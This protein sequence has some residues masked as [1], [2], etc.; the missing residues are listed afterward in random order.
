MGTTGD[1]RRGMRIIGVIAVI[2]ALASPTSS[3]SFGPFELSVGV[4]ERP[5]VVQLR[6]HVPPGVPE[7][8]IEV[9][10]IGRDVVVHARDARG[11]LMRSR[12]IPLSQA[13][14]SVAGEAEFA[15]DGALVITLYAAGESGP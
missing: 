9:H 1:L 13:V 10:I 2:A 3:R 11:L 6:L 8:S 5:G 7:S 15:A 14:S 4:E 12:A